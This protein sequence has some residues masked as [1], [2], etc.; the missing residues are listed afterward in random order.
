MKRFLVENSAEFLLKAPAVWLGT[1]RAIQI[2]VDSG[3]P[4]PMVMVGGYFLARAAM[5]VCV[6]ANDIVQATIHPRK[7]GLP[8][9]DN[10]NVDDDL[11][12]EEESGRNKRQRFQAEDTNR[13]NAGTEEEDEATDSSFTPSSSD[14]EETGEDRRSVATGEHPD[15]TAMVDVIEL[16]ETQMEEEDARSVVTRASETSDPQSTRATTG[17]ATMRYERASTQ[18]SLS[19]CDDEQ[20]EGGNDDDVR[21][22]ASPSLLMNAPISSKAMSTATKTTPTSASSSAS[23]TTRGTTMSSEDRMRSVRSAIRGSGHFDEH[24]AACD[25]GLHSWL[26]RMTLRHCLTCEASS[27]NTQSDSHCKECVKADAYLWEHVRKC[28]KSDHCLVPLCDQRRFLRKQD[29]VSSPAY[30]QNSVNSVRT[31][32]AF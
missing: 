26:V 3:I 4:L 18:G 27:A 19:T 32:I 12:I 2:S 10:A 11:G 5:R 15:E 6:T 14:N 30:S 24:P 22:T 13:Q 23:F 7:R 28:T 20:D 31:G 25:C 29:R 9:D 21:S 8:L 1:N 16:I 17:S